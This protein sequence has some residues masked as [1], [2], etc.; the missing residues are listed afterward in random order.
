[1]VR[2]EHRY[3]P[4]HWR[5]GKKLA[6]GARLDSDGR[7]IRGGFLSEEDRKAPIALARDGWR[8]VAR[9]GAP[10]CRCG[11]MKA[12]SCKEAAK[13]L[14]FADGSCCRHDRRANPR[15]VGQAANPLRLCLRA[16]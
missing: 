1:M 3:T 15:S 4:T 10:L 6:F 11:W 16:A 9:R 13:V 2:I 14:L 7:M 8:L 5:V 12:L